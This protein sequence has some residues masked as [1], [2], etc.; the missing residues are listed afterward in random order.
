V[1]DK[2]RFNLVFF[3]KTDPSRYIQNQNATSLKRAS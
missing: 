1:E 3:N 2:L